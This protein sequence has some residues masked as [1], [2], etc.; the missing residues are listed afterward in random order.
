MH[1]RML[2]C[3][4]MFIS[5]CFLSGCWDYKDINHR[6]MPVVLGIAKEEID[7]A[8]KVFLQIPLPSENQNETR[9]VIDS[10]KTINEII[11]NIS[12]NMESQVDLLHVKVIV[13][14]QEIAEEGFDDLISAFLR[15]RDISSKALFTICEEDLNTFFSKMGNHGNEGTVLLDYF[16][17]DAGWN[18]QIALTRVWHIYRSIHSL[19]NDV[20]VPILKLGDTTMVEQTG[21][22]VIK[23]GRMVSRID[24][25]ETL[26]YNAFNGESTQGIIEVTDNAA[27]R[28]V[29]NSMR[30][31]AT[32]VQ[33]KPKL[34]STVFLK[35]T[36]M[37][38]KQ[39]TTE[40]VIKEQL[41][42]QLTERFNEM[43][44]KI[45]QVESDILGIGQ[46]FRNKLPRSELTQW[47]SKYYPHITTDIHFEVDIQNSGNLKM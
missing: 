33:G 38:T 23:E 46:L 36:I 42:Q 24:S 14:G 45:Q 32:F 4:I 8:Y 31:K 20:A 25:K 17:K 21:S 7:D 2:M 28:I 37:E 9:I 10:G 12:T 39:G 43:F 26:L 30:H 6:V 40:K 19:T 5:I 13:V 34:A 35:V 15:S 18:P 22:A 3:L 1:K 29:E 47:R 41:N 27:V 44:T 16:E 11:N